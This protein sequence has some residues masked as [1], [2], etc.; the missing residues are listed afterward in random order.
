MEQEQ[1]VVINSPKAHGFKFSVF[2]KDRMYYYPDE[3]YDMSMRTIKSGDWKISNITR[4][5]T[6]TILKL[7]PIQ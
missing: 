5:G 4:S 1:V 2:Y 6:T 7:I 3:K